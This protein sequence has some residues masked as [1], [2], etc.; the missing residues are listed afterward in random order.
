MQ[1][2]NMH[3]PGGHVER[4]ALEDENCFIEGTNV[5]PHFHGN[6]MENG[7]K[8]DVILFGWR[9]QKTQN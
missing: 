6:D 9:G 7:T 3:H 1:D 2:K 8:F 5:T 4:E